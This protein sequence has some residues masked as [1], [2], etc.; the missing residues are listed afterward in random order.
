M[1]VSEM[2]KDGQNVQIFS[3]KISSGDVKYS[4]VPMVSNTVMPI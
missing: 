2:G 1:G 4:L 3:Y